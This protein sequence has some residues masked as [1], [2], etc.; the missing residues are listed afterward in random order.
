MAEMMVDLKRLAGFGASRHGWFN[1]SPPAGR[2]EQVMT[3]YGLD[4]LMG[5]PP[6]GK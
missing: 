1:A 2:V 3:F 6:S 5:P 4:R